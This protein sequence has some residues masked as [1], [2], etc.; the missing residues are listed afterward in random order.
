MQKRWFP[1]VALLLVLS[2]VAAGLAACRGEPTAQLQTVKVKQGDIILKVNADGNL[3]LVQDGKLAFGT[4]GTVADVRVKEGDRV[5]TGQF[6]AK[7]D[8]V[9]LERTVKTAELAIQLAE[10][11]LK[12]AEDNIRATENDLQQAE[13]GVKSAEIDLEL[14]SNNYEKLIVPY[15]YLTYRFTIPESVDAIRIGVQRIKEA[16]VEFQ[17][18]MTGGQY[19]LPYIQDRLAEANDNLS[20]AETMLGW[21]LDAGIRP[22]NADYWTMRS[23]QLQIDKARLGLD[24][25]RSMVAKVT[26][27]ADSVK[28]MSD[29]AR[30]AVEKAKYDR[31]AAR[32]MLDKVVI[33]A[34]FDGVIAAV[35]TKVGDLLSPAGYTATA[36]RLID[37]DRLELEVK[38]DEADI[39]RV[40]LGQKAAVTLDALPDQVFNGTVTFIGW[41]ADIEAGV[42]SFKVKISLGSVQ[43]GLLKEG[44]SATADIIMEERHGVLLVPSRAIK[45]DSQGKPVVQVVVDGQV[46]DRAVVIGISDGFQTEII[47]GLAEG[48]TVVESRA[49]ADGSVFGGL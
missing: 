13:Q 36:I 17:K 11:D 12:Q 34:P 18:A 33:T 41:L 30:L 6:L 49:Q 48:E 4:S 29:K 10:A 5:T 45:Q 25:A 15:P 27:A 7:L 14:A 40:S 39:A 23:L 19:S 38:V 22:A 31:D 16:Q 32:E 43:S 2:L 28:G 46:Q 44:M 26:L 9:S 24:N 42:V 21:G 35:N 1:L 47:S 37:P 3:A 20:Q 8:T